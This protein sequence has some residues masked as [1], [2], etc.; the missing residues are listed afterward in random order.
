[1]VTE[2]LIVSQ[3]EKIVGSENF[4]QSEEFFNYYKR[5]VTEFTAPTISAVLTPTSVSQVQEI[6]RICNEH[7]IRLY[8]ISTGLNWGLGSKL[9]H[10]EDAVIMDLKKLNKIRFVSEEFRYAIIEP[11]VTQKQLARYLQDHNLQVM[12][13]VTGSSP[14][15]SYL[16]NMLERGTTFQGHKANDSRGFEVVT[17]EGTIL[18]TGWW[19]E[20]NARQTTLHYKHGVGPNMTDMFFESNLGIVTGAVVSLMPKPEVIKMLWV[21]F[22]DSVLPKFMDR[23]K[24]V[25]ADGLLST[26]SHIGNE[27]RMRFANNSKQGVELEW[28]AV[29]AVQGT[30]NFVE[31]AE[32]EIAKYLGDTATAIRFYDEETVNVSP[33]PALKEL[34][35]LHTGT[36][37]EIFL[38]GM[39]RSYGAEPYITSFDIDQGSI[40]MVFC[41]PMIPFNGSSIRKCMD[42]L[43]TTAKQYNFEIAAT[44]NPA[45]DLYIEGVI[46]I[47]F[48]RTVPKQIETAQACNT[49]LHAAL[50]K[51]G[52][53]FYRF[54][55]KE[56]RNY[57]TPN[58]D[59]WQYVAKVKAA[60]DPNGIIAPFRYNIV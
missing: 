60:L 49:A 48:D 10:S 32:K 58:S 9:P 43:H 18:R 54:D 45:N 36:P 44:L 39:H 41:L 3:L 46:N 35:K 56:M 21:E 17:A 19:H 53:R 42:V 31:F 4:F 27:K 23:Y 52:F 55:T 30:S 34:Y 33:D 29:C 16:G 38:E 24:K 20:H 22:P 12:S 14:N 7:K 50:Y 1:M 5:N 25:Y 59:Y 57:I 37:S 2:N 40:G 26:F 28:T 6:A 8:P 51:E 13:S 15:T 47:Y 11:G